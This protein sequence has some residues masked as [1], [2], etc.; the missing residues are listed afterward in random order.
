MDCRGRL[1]IP[2]LGELESLALANV[3][4]LPKAAKC[5]IGVCECWLVSVSNERLVA[6]VRLAES[7]QVKGPDTQVAFASH[8]GI[9]VRPSV[10][11]ASHQFAVDDA[12]RN[13][14]KHRR[15]SESGR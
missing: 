14:G 3:L 13:R 4:A 7:Q 6:D 5:G 2:S 1:R 8:D 11:V 10:C 15:V 12:L 9:E